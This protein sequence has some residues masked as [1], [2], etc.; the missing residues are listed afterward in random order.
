MRTLKRDQF[1]LKVL[2]AKNVTLEAVLAMND[3]EV[4]E[5]NLS[6][7]I[8]DAIN[9][10][11]ERGGVTAEQIAEQIADIMEEPTTT[12]DPEI[13]NAYENKEEV[14]ESPEVQ[15]E[16]LDSGE[17]EVEIEEPAEP[18]E[19]VDITEPVVSE[20]PKVLEDIIAEVVESTTVSKEELETIASGIADK[21]VPSMTKKIKAV[22]GERDVDLTVLREV[23]KAQVKVNKAK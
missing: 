21:S 2:A 10:Q 20:I 9:E 8:I 11:R 12:I 15:T 1:V 13:V 6:R 14:V 3:K 19:S 16:L 5:L 7:T 18:T 4:Q 17:S 23:V 22:I